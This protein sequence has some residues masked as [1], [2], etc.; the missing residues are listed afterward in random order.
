MV[1]EEAQEVKIVKSQIEDLI[2]N[3]RSICQALPEAVEH[4]NGFGNTVFQVRGKTF[5]IISERYGLSFKS[6]Q[7]MQEILLQEERF[8]KTPYI[9]RHGWVSIRKINNEDW[10]EIS[11]WIQEAYLRTAPKRLLEE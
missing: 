2:E 7:E 10:N 3:M 9:G 6:G 1:N 8:F 11:E 5:A 4:I